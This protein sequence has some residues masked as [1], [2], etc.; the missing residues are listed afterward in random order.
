[1]LT[2]GFLFAGLTDA[3]E[4]CMAADDPVP[5]SVRRCGG[6]NLLYSVAYC[7]KLVTADSLLTSSWLRISRGAYGRKYIADQACRVRGLINPAHM[8]VESSNPRI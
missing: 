6:C 4:V 8:S 2:R 1:M 7:L 3:W 5:A